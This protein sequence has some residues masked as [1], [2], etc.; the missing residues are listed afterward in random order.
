MN[1][2]VDGETERE[3]QR[4]P[5]YHDEHRL[6]SSGYNSQ[7]TL[8]EVHRP[9][10]ATFD[11]SND[12]DSFLLPFERQV[13]KYGWSAAEKVDR[14]HE[15]LRGAAIRYVCSLPERTREDYVLLVEQLTQRFGKK[16][17]P[18]T[19]RWKLGELSGVDQ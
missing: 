13:R 14:L 4:L 8:Q 19:V 10:L 17:P 5:S 3:N 12:R 15:C 7:H 2:T 11:G 16:D 1:L 9:K 6:N 18:T